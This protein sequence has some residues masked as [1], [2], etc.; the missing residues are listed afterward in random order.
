M[1][2]NYE[3]NIFLLQNFPSFKIQIVFLQIKLSYLKTHENVYKQNKLSSGYSFL[4]VRKKC[5]RERERERN[6]TF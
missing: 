1:G 5:E 2:S 4:K 6:K 3:E